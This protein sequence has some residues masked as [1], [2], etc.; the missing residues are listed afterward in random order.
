MRLFVLGL[1]F[2]LAAC[3]GIDGQPSGM[4]LQCRDCPEVQVT[5]VIDGDTLDTSRG[6]V[7]LFGVDTPERGER[8]YSEVTDRLQEL[9]GSSV[10]LE[11]GPRLTD[12]FGRILAYLYTQDGVSID[13][14]LVRERLA[15]AWTWD[16]QHRDFLVGLE[17]EAKRK[18]LVAFG[19][20]GYPNC[21]VHCISR[22]TPHYFT[23][24]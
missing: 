5:Q 1:F 14:A 19:D 9:S 23:R 16:G 6:R 12:Q 17:R 10:R 7:R 20:L 21:S 8:C 22:L 13:E 24:G 4:T 11:D 3:T 15:T 2:T 18:Y